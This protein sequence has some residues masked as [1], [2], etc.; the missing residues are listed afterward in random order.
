[1]ATIYVTE[2]GNCFD[3][4]D[5]ERAMEIVFGIDRD[6]VEYYFYD[7]IDDYVDKFCPG[8]SYSKDMSPE[9]LL[10]RGMYALALR[11]ARD[12]NPKLS[13]KEIKELVDS[14]KDKIDS[15]K[16]EV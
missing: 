2:N 6:N 7:K 9:D 4:H 10:C 12:E 16:K 5:I 13:F 14:I 11:V 8:I 1:M 15:E 3:K